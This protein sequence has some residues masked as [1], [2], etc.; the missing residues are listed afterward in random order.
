MLFRKR[1]FKPM[2]YKFTSIHIKRNW[3][4]FL[5]LE[6]RA[7][8]LTRHHK[9][10]SKSGT[11][12]IQRSS[13]HC[14]STL[15]SSAFC[16]PF[17]AV[18]ELCCIRKLKTG[19]KKLA[20]RPW[21]F[22]VFLFYFIHPTWGKT[23]E[24]NAWAGQKWGKADHE[25]QQ[26]SKGVSHS[27]SVPQWDCAAWAGGDSGEHRYLHPEAKR[28]VPTGTSHWHWHWSFFCVE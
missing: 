25:E 13:F 1:N 12:R 16:L 23:A 28:S 4:Y 8:L 3:F 27:H 14:V 15:P 9:E 22:L 21:L 17:A 2:F 10:I 24:Y 11:M 26:G 18:H 5:T 7:T 20:D 6:L 19:W